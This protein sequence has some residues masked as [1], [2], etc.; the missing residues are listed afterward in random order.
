MCVFVY[1]CKQE[2]STCV[3]VHVHVSVWYERVCK[4][5][6]S[7]SVCASVWHEC[8]Y[9]VWVCALWVCMHLCEQVCILACEH[10][11]GMSVCKCVC[12]WV[13]NISVCACGFE[14]VEWVCMHVCE[15][16]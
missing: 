12:E 9:I 15:C 2:Y 5:V 8:V 4:C 3:C 10:M 13:R 14:Y 16:V 7:I 11:C 1:V 6:S